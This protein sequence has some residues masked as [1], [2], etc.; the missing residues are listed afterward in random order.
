MDMIV[1]MY[2]KMYTT[3]FNAVTTALR[4]MA[5]GNYIEAEMIL[6]KAQQETEEIYILW[7]ERGDE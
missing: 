5:V 4:L 7:E 1:R 3:L 6:K 2:R